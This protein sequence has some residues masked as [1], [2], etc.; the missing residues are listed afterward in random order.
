MMSVYPEINPGSFWICKSMFKPGISSTD[1][2]CKVLS[3]T[4]DKVHIIRKTTYGFKD[5]PPMSFGI[6]EFL[7]LYM[8]LED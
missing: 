8:R 7:M 3:V 6:D 4:E 2:I 1:I 5:L